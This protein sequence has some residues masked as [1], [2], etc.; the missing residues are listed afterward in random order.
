MADHMVSILSYQTPKEMQL[1]AVQELQSC[2]GTEEYYK[3]NLVAV[4][5][6]QSTTGALG[7]LWSYS[8]ILQE[9]TRG[10]VGTEECYRS[11]REAVM[12]L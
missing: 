12:V 2:I 10:S 6:Q 1:A 3:S 7:R 4:L 11:Y 8:R 5:V 9:H